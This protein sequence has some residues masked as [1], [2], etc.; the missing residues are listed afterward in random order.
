VSLDKLTNFDITNIS[1]QG[2]NFIEVDGEGTQEYKLD[3]MALK[4]G[5]YRFKLIFR[6]KET[7]ETLY[8]NFAI[9]VVDLQ[10]KTELK[11]EMK[12]NAPQ[13]GND[14]ESNFN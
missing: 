8:H 11:E 1:G 14:K 6:I 7:G 2:L 10:N 12:D 5:M 3:F 9:T 4:L 13:T